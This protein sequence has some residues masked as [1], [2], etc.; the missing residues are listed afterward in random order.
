MSDDGD[1]T[2]LLPAMDRTWSSIL[3]LADSLRSDE[4]NTPTRCPG[5][6]VHDQLA[7]VAALPMS[8]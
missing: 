3:E 7:L 5:L 8:P 1:L 2:P 6:D 4:L